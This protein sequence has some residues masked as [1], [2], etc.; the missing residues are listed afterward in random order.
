MTR[1]WKVGDVAMVTDPVHGELVMTYHQD[2]IRGACWHG[3][4]D[5]AVRCLNT[6]QA[7]DAR[8]LVVIDL[9][10]GARAGWPVLID[11]LRQASDKTNLKMTFG[12]LIEQIEAQTDPPKPPRPT[13]PTG[14]GAVAEDVDGELYVRHVLPGDQ[15][16]PRPWCNS[17]GASYA[18]DEFT[19]IAVLSHGWQSQGGR[20]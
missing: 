3:V 13:E 18:W 7:L 16:K 2:G 9:P 14:Q 6:D 20:R 8:Q 1:D 5:G 15:S 4:V 12:G 19:P 10:D 11:A 17:T